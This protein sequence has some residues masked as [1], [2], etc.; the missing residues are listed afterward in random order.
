[1]LSKDL[2]KKDKGSIEYTWTKDG[3]IITSNTQFKIRRHRFLKIR[4]VTEKDNG[5]YKCVAKN[6]Y[7]SDSLTF[8]VKLPCKY[9]NF[10]CVPNYLYNCNTVLFV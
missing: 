4:R 3:K 2:N 7:G 5:V 8:N 6:S 10:R 9:I 1:M